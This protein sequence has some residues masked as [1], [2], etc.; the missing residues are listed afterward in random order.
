MRVFRSWSHDL[1]TVLSARFLQAIPFQTGWK[2]RAC[3]ESVAWPCAPLSTGSGR[4][5]KSFGQILT[6]SLQA[7]A[8]TRQSHPPQTLRTTGHPGI[9]SVRA[10]TTLPTARPSPQPPLQRMSGWPSLSTTANGPLQLLSLQ[11][12]I[13]C[14]LRA[15]HHSS[16]RICWATRRRGF[17]M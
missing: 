9:R 10:R 6:H 4:G 2:K 11:G 12:Q 15:R 3:Q 14:F 13:R 17:R 1:S 7:G 5:T 16:C 8:G